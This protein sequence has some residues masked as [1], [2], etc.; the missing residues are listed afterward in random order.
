[1]AEKGSVL[2]GIGTA[3]CTAVFVIVMLGFIS[4][5]EE[6]E[7]TVS[8]QAAQ[9]GMTIIFANNIF[10]PAGEE[11][12]NLQISPFDRHPN[13]AGHELI[14]EF[15]GEALTRRDILPD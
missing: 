7:R 10:P 5:G 6:I 11:R 13:A 3:W 9:L 8:Q 2:R 4:L 1:M 15:V 14:A 12:S